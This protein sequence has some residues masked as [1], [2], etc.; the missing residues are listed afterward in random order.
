MHLL[1]RRGVIAMDVRHR[2]LLW[3]LLLLLT[4]VLLSYPV[5]L[6][7]DYHVI[8]APYIFENLPL[9]AALFCV[10]ML[11][12]LVLAVSKRDGANNLDWENLALACV[13]GVVFWGFWA[14]ITPYGSYADD[15]W[16][17]GHVRWLLQGSSIPLGHL[18]LTYFDYPGVHLLV[19]AISEVTGLG[20]AGS[21]TIFLVA[22]ALTF[23][24]L[25]YIVLQRILENP[26]LALLGVLLIAV[27]SV[28]LVDKMHVFGPASFGL[29]LLGG[30]LVILT[31]SEARV[32]GAGLPDRLVMLVLFSSMVIGYFANSFL[33]LLILLG[34][35]AVQA[36]ARD[37]AR[38]PSPATISL[39]A[40]LVLTWATCWTWHTFDTLAGFLPRVEEQLLSGGFLEVALSLQASN[41]GGS[42]P[43]WANATRLAGWALL[44]LSTILGLSSL[45][46]LKRL[47]L[48]GRIVTGALL[49][50]ILLFLMGVFA[51]RGGYQFSRFLLYGPLFAVPAA[52][53]YLTRGDAFRK[54]ALALLTVV[55]FVLALPAFISS[56]NTV[57]T[58]AIYLSDVAGG[59]FLE[60]HSGEKGARYL[61]YGTSTDAMALASYY[62]PNAATRRVAEKD[63][64]TGNEDTVWEEVDRLLA[65]FMEPGI[66]LT[67]EKLFIINEKS[68]VPYRHVVGIPLDDPN[69]DRVIG[70]LWD[71]NRIY[72]NSHLEMYVSKKG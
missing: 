55:V 13:F 47:S 71:N 51:T 25:L 10:W 60:C 18:N 28:P 58:D 34:I 49:G 27:V 53:L 17:Q 19:S 21:R 66:G 32:F 20:V 6:V 23:S 38:R 29:T 45:F 33:V 40:A 11:L 42:L 48:G 12:L 57:S 24:A 36:L 3:I 65:D 62:V 64:Y 5:R 67:Q 14:V 1:G 39:F 68:T 72:D 37:N 41:V 9:F 30:F 4:V 16:N 63:I 22:N 46:R 70:L 31:R 61:L 15:I 8:Q 56:V 2:V 59:T 44:G 54:G 69:W 52:L 43:L 35:Y 26:R 7:C 50:V